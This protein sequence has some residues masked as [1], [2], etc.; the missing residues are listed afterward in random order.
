MR[1]KKVNYKNL[2]DS[3]NY[4]KTTLSKECREEL[5]KYTVNFIVDCILIADS[6]SVERNAVIKR[7]LDTF[8]SI[9]ESCDFSKLDVYK[10]LTSKDCK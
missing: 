2:L 6:Y 5:S 8:N 9:G 4:R 10:W 1:T 7:V 3:N